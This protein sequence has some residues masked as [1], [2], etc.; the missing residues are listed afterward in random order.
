MSCISVLPRHHSVPAERVS[1]EAGPLAVGY[2]VVPHDAESSRVSVW[3]GAT[4]RPPSDATLHVGIGQSVPLAGSWAEFEVRGEPRF[5]SQ[6]I[7]VDGLEPGRRYPIRLRV[8][9]AEAASGTAVTFPEQLPPVDARPFTCLVGSCFA[10][11]TDAAGA[12]GA[13]YR[14][15][16]AGMQPDVKFLCGDQVYLDTPFPR[17]LLNVIGEN[18]LSAELLATYI[19]TW[20][21]GGDGRGF[22]EVLRKG[23]TYF[24]SDDH[25][26]W[27]NAPLPTVTVRATWW[28]FGDR[29]AAW[30]RFATTLYDQFQTPRRSAEFKVGRLSFRVLDTRLDRTANRS[31]FCADAELGA[32]AQ[33]LEALDGPGVLVL[34]QPILVEPRG[35]AG[36]LTDFGLVDFAQYSELVRALMRSRHDLLVLTGDVH[37]GR[38]AGC[39]LPSGAS[40]VEVIASPF[41]LVDARVGGK[42]S[43]PP[44][45]FPAIPI[46]GVTQSSVWFEA[47]HNLATNQFSTLEFSADGTRVLT[48]VRSWPIPPPGTRP[49]P[50]LVFKQR[51][52]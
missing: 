34:G 14:S 32:V 42:W 35:V 45:V 37:Y 38:V 12:A 3:V 1:G 28:P 27:N 16:P 21:Q 44:L 48:S 26:L 31:H 49:S 10:H 40:L 30:M 4:V 8:N 17:Y 51:L 11:Y 9:G 18:D 43:R 47:S 2:L 23:A 7:E 50:R 20:T 22:N 29:G 6:R 46:A 19:A 52:S 15:L 36:Y 41:A 39:R 25:E 24:G 13:A 5:W 33:W